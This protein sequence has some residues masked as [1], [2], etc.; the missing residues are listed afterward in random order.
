MSSAK[1][2]ATYFIGSLFQAI[3]KQMEAVLVRKHLHRFPYAYFTTTL[4][5]LTI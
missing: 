2:D 4:R 5:P 1:P 3:G